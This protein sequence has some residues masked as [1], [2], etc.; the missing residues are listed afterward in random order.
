MKV[1]ALNV[2]FHNG[3]RIR[4]GEEFEVADGEKASWFAPVETVATKPAKA[5]KGG[6]PEPKA[7][8]E[9]GKDES[10]TFVEAHAKA[11]LA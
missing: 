8:S 3:S 2:G 5:G 10:K 9:V 7:L 1:I 6:R 11:D 4:K